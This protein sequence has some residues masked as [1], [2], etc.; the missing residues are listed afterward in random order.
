MDIRLD[1]KWEDADSSK[2]YVVR[3]RWYYI[4]YIEIVRR[5]SSDY[6]IY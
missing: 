1:I 2:E 4:K 3:L 6:N 5:I